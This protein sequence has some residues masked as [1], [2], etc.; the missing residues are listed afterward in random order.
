MEERTAEAERSLFR[1]E[2]KLIH[3][4]KQGKMKMDAVNDRIDRGNE[5]LLI[6]ER[7]RREGKAQTEAAEAQVAFTAMQR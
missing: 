1:L 7:E 6:V 2:E 5:Q 4:R 3:M